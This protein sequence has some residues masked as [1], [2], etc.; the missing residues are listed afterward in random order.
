MIAEPLIRRIRGERCT[1]LPHARELAVWTARLGSALVDTRRLFE[2]EKLQARSVEFK[3]ARFGHGVTRRARSGRR[4]SRSPAT[5]VRSEPCRNESM[6]RSIPCRAQRRSPAHTR[7][8]Q[9]ARAE[10]CQTHERPRAK[11][12]RI[13]SYPPGIS[14]ALLRNSTRAQPRERASTRLRSRRDSAH[15]AR[16]FA[17]GVRGMVRTELSDEQDVVEGTSAM[18]ART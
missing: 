12:S 11:S 13:A 5:P 9:S 7:S 2:R 3:P 16:E 1:R 8:S 6:S 4:R 17:A 14:S 18:R 10:R 15:R